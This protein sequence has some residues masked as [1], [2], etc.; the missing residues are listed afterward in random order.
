MGNLLDK[1][2][3]RVFTGLIPGFNAIRLKARVNYITEHYYIGTSW[4]FDTTED[5]TKF[6]GDVI[7]LLQDYATSDYYYSHYIGRR[8][9]V[10]N[11]A[12]NSLHDFTRFAKALHSNHNVPDTDMA[13]EVK[14]GFKR[15]PAK[16]SIIARDYF[17][18]DAD[19][20]S[21][22][23]EL[24]EGLKVLF[25]YR[26][27]GN[28][29]SADFSICDRETVVVYYDLIALVEVIKEAINDQTN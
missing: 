24:V 9:E 8:V 7:D 6:L 20:K 27:N 2:T 16:H 26:V 22:L 3:K 13:R 4:K 19:I 21:Q 12:F 1:I 5:V 14:K 17:L 15:T 29:N 23:I 11:P 28:K 18:N 10:I 25:N